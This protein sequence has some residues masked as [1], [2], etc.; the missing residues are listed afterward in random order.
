[1]NPPVSHSLVQS[2]RSV[3]DF[4][5]LDEKT[6]LDIVGESMNLF[7][8]AGHRIFQ[9][10]DAGAALYVMLEGECSIHRGDSPSDGEVAH[11]RAGDAFGEMSLLMEAT[12]SRTA[13][14]VTDCEI[15]V[16][17]KQAFANLLEDNPGL[18]A[19]F[20]Q[21]LASRPIPAAEA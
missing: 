10:G 12:H 6:L 8:K 7:W 3:L 2:L 18:E 21:V 17:P 16:L 15:L 4:S 11:P 20:Q 1:M 5:T 9:T 19:H 14:A 13:T